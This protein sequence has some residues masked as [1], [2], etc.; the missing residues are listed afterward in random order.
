MVS[1]WKNFQKKFSGISSYDNWNFKPQISFIFH[2]ERASE[3]RMAHV[4]CVNKQSKQVE[5]ND[6]QKSAMLI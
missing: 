6:D 2:F 5:E 3:S 1:A 4:L